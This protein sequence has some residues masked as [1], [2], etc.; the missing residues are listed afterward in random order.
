MIENSDYIVIATVEHK[1][2]VL[3]IDGWVKYECR[4]LYWLKAPAP[5]SKEKLAL[6]EIPKPG[7]KVQPVPLYSLELNGRELDY[8]S[9]APRSKSVLLVDDHEKPYHR[10]IEGD[11]LMPGST[12]HLPMYN[13]Y[14]L[15]FL[16]K[17]DDGKGYVTVGDYQSILP[18][19][20]LLDITML[21]PQPQM[22]ASENLADAQSKVKMTLEEEIRFILKDYI[23][24]KEKELVL[25]N[26]DL[27][28]VLKDKTR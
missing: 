10:L 2:P 9:G 18:V 7:K 25:I 17:N 8:P 1:S 21:P 3:Y 27:E 23:A 5:D 22:P 28:E 12:S 4:F 24:F 13:H 6:A 16:Q 14:H 11:K 20:P 15:L 19:S 26:K